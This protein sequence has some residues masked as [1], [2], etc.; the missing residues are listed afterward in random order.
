MDI[1]NLKLYLLNMQVWQK[2]HRW[3]LDDFLFVFC[4][5]L[6]SRLIITI[7]MQLIAP[8]IPLN[9][10]SFNDVGQDTLQIKNFIPHSSWELFTHWDGEH[11]RNIATKGYTYNANLV[12]KEHIYTSIQ[13]YN[14]AFFP[15]FPL[16]IKMLM[17]IGIP[18]DIAGT[19]INNIVFLV[20]LLIFYPWINKM[21]GKSIAKW[22]IVV[23]TWFP[24]SLFC[25]VTYTESFFLLLTTS[26][27]IC[28]E[29]HQYIRASFFGILATATRPPGLVLIPALLVFSWME[30]R[31]LIAYLSA[32]VMAGGLIV[33][34]LFCWKKFNEPFAF[35][36]AQS[37]WPQPSWSGLLK[38]IFNPIL[39]I[40]L[41]AYVYGI[42]IFLLLINGLLFYFSAWGYLMTV[43]I[44][45]P[46]V[47][48][49]TALLQITMPVVAIWLMWNFRRKISPMLLIYSCCFLIFLIL[50]GT[51]ASLH[52]HIYTIAPMSL[53]LGI[54]F[55]THPRAGYISVGSF[56][57]LLLFYS[58][59]F[60]WWDWIA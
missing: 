50:T 35:L 40:E 21:H 60:A 7:G 10:V 46:F 58:V 19:V 24:I 47:A 12:Y 13:R 27:L 51:K 56:G 28:F 33:F 36:L 25:S 59:R 2:L 38:D 22:T 55:S 31:H 1:K 9:P 14:I 48:Y 57:F 23:M 42:A 17:S 8:A 3:K 4:M 52:R 34:S 32:V 16:V 43:I 53:A 49:Y 54:L 29:S 30:R 39:E 11:Y 18:F 45:L 41:P 37:G 44:I 6:L 15:L 20:T 26:T 5:W